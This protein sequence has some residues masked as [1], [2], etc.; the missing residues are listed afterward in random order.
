MPIS[1]GQV[2]RS[3]SAEEDC[4]DCRAAQDPS[5]HSYLGLEGVEER[6]H[7]TLNA[8]VGVEIA[9]GTLGLAKWDVD[10]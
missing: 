4:V 1:T 6:G 9:V 2:G 7:Q 3:T 8:L 5:P 10:V